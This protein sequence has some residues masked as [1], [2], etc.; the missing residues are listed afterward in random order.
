L[1]NCGALAF[2]EQSR[3]HDLT[4]WKLQAIMVHV[5]LVF[6]DVPK[7]RDLCRN[8]PAAFAEQVIEFDVALE[9]KLRAGKQTQTLLMGAAMVL[10]K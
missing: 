5:P 7:T 3:Q 6:I 9:G 10:S 8:R 1:Q 4:A 2:H